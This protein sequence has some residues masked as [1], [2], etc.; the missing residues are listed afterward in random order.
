M[1]LRDLGRRGAYP[2]SLTHRFSR[3]TKAQTIKK[4]FQR[5]LRASGKPLKRF[6]GHTIANTRLKPGVN[7][8]WDASKLCAFAS[9]R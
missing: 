9:L 1:P 4:P 2:V 8:D 5:F 3:V 7:G 6:A